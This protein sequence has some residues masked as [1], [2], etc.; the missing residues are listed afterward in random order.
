MAIKDYTTSAD[1]IEQ[2]FA[3]NHVGHFLLTELLMNKILLA[4]TNARIVFVASLGYISGGIRI[5]D[6]NFQVINYTETTTCIPG[7][8]NRTL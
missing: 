3:A 2:H 8:L 5:D 6:Y 7:L 1:G 4:G